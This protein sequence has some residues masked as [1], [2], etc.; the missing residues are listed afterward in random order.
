[1]CMV[2]WYVGNIV[3]NI[4]FGF[5][6]VGILENMDGIVGLY[7]WQWFFFIEGIVFIVVVLMV[8]IILFGWLSDMNVVWLSK[9]GFFI[10]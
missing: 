9:K 6:V 7:V 2:I 8:F 4:L 3:V 10:E 5:F 1:M